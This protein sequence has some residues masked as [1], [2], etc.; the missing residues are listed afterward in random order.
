MKL[1]LLGTAAAEGWPG[2]YC[3]CN[4]CQKARELGGKNIRTR[5]SMMI[6]ETVKI[7]FPPDT[8][9]HVLTYGIDLRK[10]RYLLITHNHDDH[11]LPADILYCE[12][13]FVAG[14]PS[15]PFTVMGPKPVIDRFMPHR[16]NSNSPLTPLVLKPYV[17]VAMENWGFTPILA[18]HMNYGESYNY[19]VTKEGKTLLYASDTGW[20]SDETWVFLTGRRIDFVVMEC[21]SGGKE[22]NY[23]GHLSITGLLKMREKL[24][25]IG[26]IQS[27]TPYIATHFSHNG[28]LL[29]H[30]LEAR[31][32]PHGVEVGYDGWEGEA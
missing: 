2:L 30:E 9:H 25:E 28:G 15:P 13:P 3:A 18:S 5:S 24:M 26:A 27:A 22:T 6:D 4:A 21:T 23:L 31:M 1:K 17:T 11:F 16:E 20:Y 32:N 19:L 29:H 8:Y 7:D 12:S 14:E 10:V